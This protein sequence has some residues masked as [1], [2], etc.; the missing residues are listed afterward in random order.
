MPT[1]NELFPSKYLAASDLKGKDWVVRIQSITPAEEVGQAKDVRPILFFHEFPKGLVLNK[2]NAKRISKLYGGQ[3]DD[4][5][6]KRVTLYPSECDFRDETVDCIRV[7]KEP[8]PVS[9][10]DPDDDELDD[11][12]RAALEAI[13]K[14]KAAK[15]QAATT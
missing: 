11:E 1:V 2:T 5:I 3:T 10:P 13:R 14:K 9:E 8:P 7:R 15:K 6:G 4:W 12:E